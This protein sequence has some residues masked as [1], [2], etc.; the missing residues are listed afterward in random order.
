MQT[1][2]ECYARVENFDNVRDIQSEPTGWD[3][4]MF[5]I[6]TSNV[7]LRMVLDGLHYPTSA[8]PEAG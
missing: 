2:M 7:Q 5:T 8:H 1:D 6:H 3:T 4:V